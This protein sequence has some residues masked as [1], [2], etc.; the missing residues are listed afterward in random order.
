MAMTPPR[1]SETPPPAERTVDRA[2]RAFFAA[3]LGFVWV[4]WR[5]PGAAPLTASPGSTP[6]RYGVAP[7]VLA[8]AVTIGL[9]AVLYR[10]HHWALYGMVGAYAALFLLLLTSG[11]FGPYTCFGAYG[12]PS[13]P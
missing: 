9:A 5:R 8:W 12:Y 7:I 2:A 1:N 3:V 6:G 10:I 11:M 13:P 4:A